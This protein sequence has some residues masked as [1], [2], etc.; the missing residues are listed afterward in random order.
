VKIS[1]REKRLL[2][3]LAAV[4]VF[5][6]FRLLWKLATPPPAAPASIVAV[7]TA[8][9]DQVPPPFEVGRDVF[10]YGPPPAPPKPP[11]PTA[12]ELEAMRRAAEARRI[13]NETRALEAA[14][15]RPP[16]VTLRYLG[17]FGPK[18]GKIAVL[19]SGTGQQIWNARVGDVVD[20]K[21][22]LREIGFESVL[23]GFVGFEDHPPARLAVGE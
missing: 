3:L 7:R 1:K 10:R 5:A 18:D 11:P 21:F 9:L 13:E 20:G 17:N 12:A 4:A 2:L 15:P 16:A 22:V 19:A 23:L 8:E 14:I 6:G